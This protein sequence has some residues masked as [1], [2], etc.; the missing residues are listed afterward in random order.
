MWDGKQFTFGLGKFPTLDSLQAHFNSKPVISGQSGMNDYLSSAWSEQ[1]WQYS[2]RHI[3][4]NSRDDNLQV[5]ID[6]HITIILLESPGLRGGEGR[7]AW[8]TLQAHAPLLRF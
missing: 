7:K 4:R 1:G 3:N 5:D 6:L 8:Y 2:T